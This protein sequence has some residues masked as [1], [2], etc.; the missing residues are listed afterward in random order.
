M[1]YFADTTRGKNYAKDPAV[2]FFGGRYLM[3]YS[4]PPWGDGRP[5]D[6]WVV[7]VAESRDLDNWTKICDLPRLTALEENGFCA[8]GA[9]VLDGTV[10][11]FYQ[12]YGN[13][14]NDAICH[15]VSRDGIRF[16]PNETNPV[17]HPAGDWTCGRAIDAD[18]IPFRG[19]LWLYVATRDPKMEIQKLAVAS[20][21][22]DGAIP[23]ATSGGRSV[24]IPF[25]S[26][27]CRGSR[28]ASKPRR[29]ASMKEGSI[30]STAGHIT[31]VRSR[32]AA[33]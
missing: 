7:G 9:I 32:S 25:S 10:H 15:A 6:G 4:V 1:M 17:F 28:S 33:P 24:P 19:R 8:P 26:R 2:V 14:A 23:P 27:S 22:L 29:S 20:A 11:L 3:Y 31:I 21:P 5:H 13:G 16:T 30:S 18:V 12:T